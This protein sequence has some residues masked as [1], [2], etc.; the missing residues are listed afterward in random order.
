MARASARRSGRRKIRPSNAASPAFLTPRLLAFAGILGYLSPVS[1]SSFVE[2][3]DVKEYLRLNVP[4]PWF[5]VKAE[6]KAPPLTTSYGWTGAAFDYAMRFYLQKINRCAKALACGGER[7]DGLRQPRER[8]HE[9]ARP[10]HRRDREGL[11]ALVPQESAQPE[12]RR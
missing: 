10:H 1:L 11:P 4:K 2:R 7:R 6:I 3:K 12:A 9:E 5:V 8:A